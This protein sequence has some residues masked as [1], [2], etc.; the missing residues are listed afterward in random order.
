M[1]LCGPKTDA[2]DT[3][4]ISFKISQNFILDQNE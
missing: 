1:S 3:R 4:P 2:E